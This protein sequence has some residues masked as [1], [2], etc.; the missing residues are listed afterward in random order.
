LRAD[1]LAYQETSAVFPQLEGV[2]DRG[3]QS[4]VTMP[5]GKYRGE[6]IALVKG[7][8]GYCAWLLDQD[9]FADKRPQ[10]RAALV[11]EPVRRKL[12]PGDM[13]MTWSD[14]NDVRTVETSNDPT[15][16]LRLSGEAKW[17]AARR[18]YAGQHR[19]E[20]IR[21][22]MPFGKLK[23]RPLAAVIGDR[24]Y[25]KWLL[26]PN[27]PDVG[28]APGLREDLLALAACVNAPT[29]APPSRYNAQVLEGGCLL[30]RLPVA[31]R[32]VESPM[33]AT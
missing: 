30:V 7:D 29:E 1:G 15:S 31:S 8:E 28:R 16:D 14:G 2:A 18:A 22:I 10:L 6:P 5:F 3:T 25:L 33:T 27:V 23:G 19:V 21:G 12:Q 32:V 4:G 24:R 9:W 26:N 20:Y 11:A 17:G 13:V